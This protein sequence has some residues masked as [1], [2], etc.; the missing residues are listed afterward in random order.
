[1]AAILGVGTGQWFAHI[2]LM[3]PTEVLGKETPFSVKAYL[4]K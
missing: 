2:A 4:L 1:M 3:N